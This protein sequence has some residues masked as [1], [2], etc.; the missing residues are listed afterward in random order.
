MEGGRVYVYCIWHNDDLKLE[1]SW[2]RCLSSAKFFP[3]T[4]VCAFTS[5]LPLSVWQSASRISVLQHHTH[6]LH[7]SIY[8]H[9]LLVWRPCVIQSRLCYWSPVVM[10]WRCR[11][12][13]RPHWFLVTVKKHGIIPIDHQCVKLVSSPLIN[14]RSVWRIRVTGP[15]QRSPLTHKSIYY[16]NVCGAHAD[17]CALKEQKPWTSYWLPIK[18]LAYWKYCL[19]HTVLKSEFIQ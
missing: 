12:W 8:H 19:S 18:L 10:I 1:T 17:T 4:F 2:A 7:I 15:E 6:A 14:N 13:R 9:A 11:W 5:H 3:V 16:L